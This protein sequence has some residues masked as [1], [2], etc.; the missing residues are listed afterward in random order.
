MKFGLFLIALLL[1][2][3]LLASTSYNGP[4][5][6]KRTVQCRILDATTGE[7]LTGVQVRIGSSDTSILSDEEGKIII[8][9]SADITPTL[10]CSLVSFETLSINLSELQEGAVIYLSEK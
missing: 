10:T 2:F 8:E 7:A 3:S 5:P 6:I 1:Q 4:N 9:I